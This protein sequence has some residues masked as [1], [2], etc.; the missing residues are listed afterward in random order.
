MEST[1][2]DFLT[3]LYHVRGKIATG[4]RKIFQKSDNFHT[5]DKK[6]TNQKNYRKNS[7][8]TENTLLFR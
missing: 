5:A 2:K 6:C 1:S 8:N 4:R 3:V 7:K